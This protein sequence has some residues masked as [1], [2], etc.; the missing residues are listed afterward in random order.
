MPFALPLLFAAASTCSLDLAIGVDET[1]ALAVQE[2]V[3][4]E[5]R[6]R[7]DG[8]AYRVRV[9]KLGAQYVLQLSSDRGPER[10]L[11]LSSLEE[12]PTAAPR[13]VESASS[14]VSVGETRDTD[15]VV[16]GETRE[17][18]SATSRVNVFL[19]MVGGGTLGAE[20][21]AGGMLGVAAGSSRWSF[22][23]DLRLTGDAFKSV[24]MF[25]LQVAALGLWKP[26][27]DAPSSFGSLSAGMRHHF[28]SSDTSPFFGMGLGLM[29]SGI[30]TVM[31]TETGT[32][33]RATKAN[34]LGMW[35]EAGL[36]VLRTSKIGGAFLVRFDAPAYELAG[37][38][39][40]Y[41][42]LAFAMR[43]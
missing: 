2:V 36:D 22:L 30:R 12:V 19:G 16:G 4:S 24:G 27:L 26:T 23:M 34:G 25:P 32:E 33:L 40:P 37:R 20:P 15:N 14:G 8:A 41:G 31:D 29:H 21:G 35:A 7:R 28:F 5:A 38:W 42:T 13:L 39:R 17:A 18:K 43:L 11:V 9:S 3:C 6:N 10:R 1:D